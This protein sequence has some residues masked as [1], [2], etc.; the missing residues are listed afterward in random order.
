MSGLFTDEE[1]PEAV[2]LERQI[3]SVEREIELRKRVYPT[4]VANHRMSAEFAAEELAAMRAVL[5]TLKGL[6]KP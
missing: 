5:R 2:T 4:R 6:V 3:K 1:A